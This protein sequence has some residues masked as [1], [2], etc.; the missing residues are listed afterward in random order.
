MYLTNSTAMSSSRNHDQV[1]QL[2]VSSF[3]QELFSSYQTA[4]YHCAEG[5]IDSWR[6]SPCKRGMST[7]TVTFAGELLRLLIA[8][9]SHKLNSKS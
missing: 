6:R 4:T 3:R 9:D 8:S 2:V 5:S 1:T 7:L